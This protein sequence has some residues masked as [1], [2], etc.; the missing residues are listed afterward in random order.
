MNRN[1][2]YVAL[3]GGV[4]I[5]FCLITIGYSVNITHI[6]YLGFLVAICDI[7]IAGYVHFIDKWKFSKLRI[8]PSA[9]TPYDILNDRGNTDLGFNESLYCKRDIDENLE[10]LITKRNRTTSIIT[11]SGSI[12][13][14]KS[15]L[16]Y[17]F[18]KS[19]LCKKTFE[20][21]YIVKGDN[22]KLLSDNLKSNN[23][24]TDLIII[25]EVN[26]FY[27]DEKDAL[28]KLL[29]TV[30]NSKS[31]VA[32]LTYANEN[33]IDIDKTN[34]NIWIAN[35]VP[36]RNPESRPIE[37]MEIPDIEYG[38][39]IYNWCTSNMYPIRPF[40]PVI[41]AYVKELRE[42]ISNK[43]EQ[44]FKNEDA[45]EVLSAYKTIATYRRN[46]SK[47]LKYI[48]YMYTVQQEDKTLDDFNN[49][50]KILIDLG[51]IE[52]K[53]WKDENNICIEKKNGG[54][55]V[56][57][58]SLEWYRGN[59]INGEILCKEQLILE[60]D[61]QLLLEFTHRVELGG[62]GK[63]N[64]TIR[65]YLL[66]NKENE[67]NRVKALIRIDPS[68]P[69][70]YSRAITKA[71]DVDAVINLVIDLL[72][73]N[74]I[75]SDKK[76]ILITDK[77]KIKELTY[78][79]SIIIGRKKWNTLI[80]IKKEVD[81]YIS[82]GLIPDM[83]LISELLGIVLFN[84]IMKNEIYQYIKELMDKYSL[85]PD[86]YYYQRIEQVEKDFDIDQVFKAASLLKELGDDYL[87]EISRSRYCRVLLLK[88]TSK[89]KMDILFDEIINLIREKESYIIKFGKGDI[90]F[91]M[92]KLKGTNS[93][94]KG[95]L[96]FHF[97]KKLHSN[98]ESLKDYPIQSVY[99]NAILLSDTYKS[100]KR[101]YDDAIENLSNDID[102]KFLR[103]MALSLFGKISEENEYE[104]CV[105]ILNSF[106]NEKEEAGSNLKLLNKLLC[107][108]PTFDKAIDLFRS[109]EYYVN[110]NIITV[111][112]LFKVV[113]RNLR[114]QLSSEDLK[115]ITE[116]NL[117][118]NTYRKDYKIAPDNIYLSNFYTLVQYYLSSEDKLPIPNSINEVISELQEEGSIITNPI[119]ESQEIRAMPFE[120]VLKRSKAIF[121]EME[122]GI[123]IDSDII[124]SLLNAV[125]LYK[126][127][128]LYEI[129]N[130]ITKAQDKIKDRSIHYYCRLIAM[131]IEYNK[132]CSEENMN[133]S[134]LKSDILS[135]LKDLNNNSKPLFEEYI[136][137]FST[138][139]NILKFKDAK[140][141]LLFAKK[142]SEEYQNINY[143]GRLFRSKHIVDLCKKI[144][145]FDEN[146]EQQMEEIQELIDQNP[147]LRLNEKDRKSINYINITVRNG[148]PPVCYIPLQNMNHEIRRKAWDKMVR[149]G[150]I[151]NVFG[152]DIQTFIKMEVVDIICNSRIPEN[153]DETYLIQALEFFSKK[154]NRLDSFINKAYLEK[155]RFN[156]KATY[157]NFFEAFVYLRCIDTDNTYKWCQLAS[158]FGYTFQ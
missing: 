93:V 154:S 151:N 8:T 118:I 113:Y 157:D 3:G 58:K 4:I 145:G 44:L 57:N 68:D 63:T 96:L 74:Q 75:L 85:I 59:I 50:L 112:S 42:R 34:I 91:L 33:N 105:K 47:E 84:P 25:D 5:A 110:R 65:K 66:H 128:E 17:N 156:P 142:L 49:G 60:K 143:F 31:K 62:F 115:N 72:I 114:K 131:H 140:E 30:H 56:K 61:K 78:L 20:Y 103:I 43:T 29:R 152:K 95:D 88:A 38:D 45:V 24:N 1:I 27:N 129:V 11:I 2:L 81:E 94:S 121:D 106:M 6:Q 123:A 18:I 86:V 9:I 40:S 116:F 107:H 158:F 36:D 148:K 135:M 97:I 64:E 28:L 46:C 53:K 150:S 41:G 89:Y 21:V 136:D 109:N 35:N 39:D 124:T 71:S 141:I 52:I 133:L 90:L 14:G 119:L 79:I 155:R 153:I 132:Y 7:I 54:K 125:L 32:I 127:D 120:K 73:Q 126:D 149:D 139:I 83:I 26:L 144:D 76:E 98:I 13:S 15:R 111:N 23:S 19:A 16:V 10:K 92:R 55:I 134:L 147:N 51:Y 100:A 146:S 102:N 48:F 104:N 37:Y 69:T 80:E 82:R 137:I 122:K 12:G 87:D 108:A 130:K 101:I 138:A 117:I 99:V 70:Y 22:I 67:I 77:E